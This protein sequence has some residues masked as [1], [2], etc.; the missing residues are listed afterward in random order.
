MKSNMSLVKALVISY[1]EMQRQIDLHSGNWSEPEVWNL[2][3]QQEQILNSLRPTKDY[4]I[5]TN[6][7]EELA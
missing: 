4:E 2:K 7:K 6:N 3:K 1:G 5:A